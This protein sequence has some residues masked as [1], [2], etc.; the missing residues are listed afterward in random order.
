MT[1]ELIAALDRR[2]V[3]DLLNQ[4]H[5]GI[6]DESPTF[7][8][9]TVNLARESCP[10][11]FAEIEREWATDAPKPGTAEWPA[12]YL[13]ERADC[14]EA[15]EAAEKERTKGMDLDRVQAARDEE[16]SK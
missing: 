2:D 8:Q 16:K 5:G 1:P 14:L 12:W 13:T 4:A 10:A 7:A 9:M 6:L 11:A 15:I 3:L